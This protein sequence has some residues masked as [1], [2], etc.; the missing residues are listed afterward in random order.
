MRNAAY[1]KKF[2]GEVSPSILS[3]PDPVLVTPESIPVTPTLPTHTHMSLSPTVDPKDTCSMSSI[4]AA[5]PPDEPTRSA[6]VR[7]PPAWQ[8]DYL[9]CC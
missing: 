2:D 9:M 7:R 3:A 6:R 5:P 1:V 4:S 8:K